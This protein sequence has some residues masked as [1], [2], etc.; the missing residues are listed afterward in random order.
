M[1]GKSLSY[2]AI[3]IFFLMFFFFLKTE[4][5]LSSNSDEICRQFQTFFVVNVLYLQET[6]LD[7]TSTAATA[8]LATE[9]ISAL[10]PTCSN[11]SKYGISAWVYKVDWVT[12]WNCLFRVSNNVGWVHISK[13]LSHPLKALT[14]MKEEYS[15]LA[16]IAQ[17]QLIS[18][19]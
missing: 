15:L 9:T 8:P 10:C 17:V 1:T 18:Y 19:R 14:P 6:K 7:S 3:F 11:S 16:L 4:I 13:F 12:G 5:A 2:K